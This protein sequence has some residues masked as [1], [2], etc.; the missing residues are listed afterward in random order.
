[1]SKDQT[2]TL[3]MAEKFLAAIKPRFDIFQILTNQEPEFWQSIDRQTRPIIERGK[4][5]WAKN[6][7][8]TDCASAAV[9]LISPDLAISRGAALK[10]KWK[11]KTPRIR[12][13]QAEQPQDA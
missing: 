13:D 9:A 4:K 1:M 7:Q 12:L 11:R 6:T 8:I 2:S 5:K 3:K 10:K